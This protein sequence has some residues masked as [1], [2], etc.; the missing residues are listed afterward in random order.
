[1]YLKLQSDIQDFLGIEKLFMNCFN[2]I[3]WK[4]LENDFKKLKL[5][6]IEMSS[7]YF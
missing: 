3:Y 2:L 4:F 6:Q 1:M 7:I 5:N